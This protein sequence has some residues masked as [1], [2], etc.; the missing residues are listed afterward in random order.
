MGKSRYFV[1]FV[2]SPEDT[3]KSPTIVLIHLTITRKVSYPLPTFSKNEY[4]SR[5][6]CMDNSFPINV[7]SLL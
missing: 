4:V 3:G 7:V 2:L 5:G 1:S 6:L